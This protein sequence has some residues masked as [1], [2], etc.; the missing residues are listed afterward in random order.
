LADQVRGRSDRIQADLVAARDYFEHTKAVWRLVEE[1]TGMGHTY[2]IQV[3]GTGMAI[4]LADLG[5][6]AQA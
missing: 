1:L 3:P 5:A 2:D 4:T 6:H